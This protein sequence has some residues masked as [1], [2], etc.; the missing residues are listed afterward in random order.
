MCGQAYGLLED[1]SSCASKSVVLYLTDDITA[2]ASQP[3]VFAVVKFASESRDALLAC[4][5][6][7]VEYIYVVLADK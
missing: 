2:M 4:K 7:I 1:N 3:I 6:T 5:D